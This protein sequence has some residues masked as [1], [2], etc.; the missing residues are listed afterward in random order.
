MTTND[1]TSPR[2]G[3]D[4]DA[5]TKRARRVYPKRGWDGGEAERALPV[6]TEDVPALVAEVIRLRT[7]RDDIADAF[8]GLVMK[9]WRA[10]GEEHEPPADVA[11]LLLRVA[12]KHKALVGFR[13]AMLDVCEALDGVR[14]EPDYDAP[15]ELGA[16]ACD[17]VAWLKAAAVPAGHV[18]VDRM[19]YDA[20]CRLA[21]DV[22]RLQREADAARREGAVAAWAVVFGELG[23]PMPPEANGAGVYEVATVARTV[24]S[25]VAAERDAARREGA[26]AMREACAA[27]VDT[28]ADAC[29]VVAW[30]FVDAVRALSLPEAPQ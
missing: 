24:R 10:A 22:P 7:L 9:V 15:A 14:P 19:L 25:V 3:L 5:L 26:E 30:P 11:A 21:S 17:E 4:L 12:E 18:A 27:A 1:D 28:A 23:A 2:A 16:W 8:D 20:A 6:V 13:R 29:G